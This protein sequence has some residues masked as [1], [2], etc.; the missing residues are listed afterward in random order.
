M[1]YSTAWHT[2]LHGILREQRELQLLPGRRRVLNVKYNI[3]LF[4]FNLNS[5]L[6]FIVVRERNPVPEY[7]SAIEKL[8]KDVVQF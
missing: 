6:F 5:S 1:A 7:G 8:M 4:H 2:Q 3:N